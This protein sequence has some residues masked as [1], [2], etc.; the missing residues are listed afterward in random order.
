VKLVS[1]S[2]RNLKGLSF[3][4]NLTAMNVLIGSNF[5]G[6]TARLDAIRLLLLG[7]FPELG[8]TPRATFDLC[9]GR[10]LHVEGT[11]DNGE[12]L[13]RRWYLKGD[14]VKTEEQIPP[15]LE[16]AGEVVAIMLN[17]ETYL[18]LSER[19]RVSYVFAHIPNLDISHDREGIV[20]SFMGELFSA[21]GLSEDALRSFSTAFRDEPV[22]SS[23]VTP[24]E[25]IEWAAEWASEREKTCKAQSVVMNKT[26]Q[27]LAYLRTQ[28]ATKPSELTAVEAEI[29]K[30]AAEVSELR[31][32]KAQKQVESDNAQKAKRRRQILTVEL[33]GRKRALA[34]RDD[35]KQKVA[36]FEAD[37]AKI[38][39]LDALAHDNLRR[40]DREAALAVSGFERDLRQVN[41]ALESN[42]K[43][44]A[45]LG[46]K[47][48]CAY[49]GATGETWKAIKRAEIESAIA[50][51]KTKAEQITEHL[52]KVRQHATQIAGELKRA[53]DAAYIRTSKNE[54]LRIRREALSAVERTVAS[55]EGKAAELAALPEEDAKAA[56]DYLKIV[57]QMNTRLAEI[58]GLENKRRA[59]VGLLHDLKRLAEAEKTRDQANEEVGVAKLAA[60]TLRSMKS[61]F[62]AESFAPLLSTAN[63]FFGDVLRSPLAYNAARC[64]LGTWRD[65]QWVGHK[66]FS[67]AE[68]RLA[69]VAIQAA[70][71]SRSPFRLMLLDELGTIDDENAGKVARDIAAALDRALLD[72]FV[73]IDVGRARL[74]STEAELSGTRLTLETISDP[75]AAI[76]P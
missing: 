65:G 24:Q 74:Y 35:A 66:T 44:L 19:E 4:L 38:A 25:F 63:A 53:N 73:G 14:S 41:E 12:K 22:P 39:G 71:A 60:V 18:G 68:R 11:F 75:V 33:E 10:D 17:A 28:D 48:K 52:R 40:A 3:T 50:G 76:S 5:V 8:K 20:Q 58:T 23:I 46:A 45:E 15:S 49:C 2:V 36:A 47:T 55:T 26:A 32:A 51:L 31:D 27:G 62:V 1:V 70:L 72:Q 7:Y 21:E 30:A 9:S 43:E 57:Q 61:K 16:N 29:K 56:E 59:I 42:R 6:K 67:G 64:E 54:E 34:Q 37:L 69:Y 13:W